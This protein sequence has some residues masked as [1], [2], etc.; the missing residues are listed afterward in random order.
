MHDRGPQSVSSAAREAVLAVVGDHDR[1]RLVRAVDGDLLADVVGVRAVQPR[2][3]HE[4]HRLG[5]QVDVLLVLGDVAGDRLV[6]ELRELDPHLFGGDPV[7]AVAD[8]RPR[9]AGER[10]PLRRECDRRPA[11]EHVSH[12]R[13]AGPATRS[14]TSWRRTRAPSRVDAELSR[15]R[16][17]EQESGGD[18]RVERL[19]R[20]HAHLDV[21]AV[22]RV[23]HAVALVDEVALAPVD[24]R[25]HDRT[26]GRGRGRRCGSCRPSC[27]T[28]R[29][30]RR[31]VS[32][33]SAVSPKPDSSVAATASTA[34]GRP[35]SARRIASA[36]PCPAIAAVPWP[37]T[38][39]A[40]ELRRRAADR[41]TGAGSDFGGEAT[42][43]PTVAL[44]DAAAQRLAERRRRLVDLLEEVVRSVAAVDV[45]GRD[46]GRGSNSASATGNTEPS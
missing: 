12:R 17:R 14:R 20:R 2:R 16:E 40:A 23:E 33:M 27:P 21:A 31:S 37:I 29:S 11:F 43:R 41:R 6:T 3:A 18:L 22:G 28:A 5:R 1:R 46:L 36:T 42:S 8:D 4:D 7:D 15:D 10:V 35:A 32:D 9:P 26:A 44:D 34:T 30:R 45:A 13:R 24:D 19:R 25:D 38:I 39:D